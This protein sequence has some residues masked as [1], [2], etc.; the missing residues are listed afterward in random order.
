MYSCVTP[1]K[2]KPGKSSG[3]SQQELVLVRRHLSSRL[4]GDVWEMQK[5]EVLW[6]QVR[7]QPAQ[8]RP[9]LPSCFPMG[10]QCCTFWQ[11]LLHH[12]KLQ[13]HIQPPLK[14]VF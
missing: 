7:Q 4:A 8:P 10:T 3:S 13:C 11:C 1:E 6:S 5:V 14:D 9:A 2:A 12:F